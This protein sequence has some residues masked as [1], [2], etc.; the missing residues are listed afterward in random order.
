MRWSG[1]WQ[2]GRKLERLPVVGERFA[3]GSLSEGQVT[4]ICAA[5]GRLTDEQARLAE[6]ILVSLADRATPAEVARAGRYLHAV[7]N[8]DG[9]EDEADADYRRRFLLVRES[10][11]GGLEGEF[12]LP[13][14]AGARLRALLDAY[15]KPRAVG[16]DRPLRVR[17]ADPTT[18]RR[19]PNAPRTRHRHQARHGRRNRCRTRH[20]RPQQRQAHQRQRSR[21][22][23]RRHRPQQRRVPHRQPRQSRACGASPRPKEAKHP[24]KHQQTRTR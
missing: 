5:T 20:H 18:C 1:R 17:N 24:S 19:R 22:R 21:C 8:P 14:E 11:S 23:T 7:L 3:R 4:A 9:G 16:D 13:R 2:C 15:A 6:P 12:R 10:S